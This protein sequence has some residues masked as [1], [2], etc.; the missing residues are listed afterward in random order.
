MVKQYILLTPAETAIDCS[1]VIFEPC[2]CTKFWSCTLVQDYTRLYTFYS[3]TLKYGPM[4][5]YTCYNIGNNVLW[6][7]TCLRTKTNHSERS[8]ATRI[9]VGICYVSESIS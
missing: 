8:Y 1:T 4:K 2:V 9:T 7:S 6:L 5:Y 3:S